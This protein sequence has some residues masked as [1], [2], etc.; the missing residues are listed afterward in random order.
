[1]WCRRQRQALLRLCIKS[2]SAG[3][4]LE[5]IIGG[6]SCWTHLMRS[7]PTC[8]KR[9]NFM[10]GFAGNASRKASRLNSGPRTVQTVQV[11]AL[12]RV[13]LRSMHSCETQWEGA[14]SASNRV[15]KEWDCL[16]FRF[17][18]NEILV[19]IVKICLPCFTVL[20]FCMMVRSGTW[21]ESANDCLFN[22]HALAGCMSSWVGEQPVSTYA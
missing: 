7:W 9:K 21:V 12:Q 2:G 6:S 17:L 5:Y 14:H 16:G 11:P 19:Q 4:G 18:I 1:M 3:G 13:T 15:S 10:A 20:H 22:L 8:S